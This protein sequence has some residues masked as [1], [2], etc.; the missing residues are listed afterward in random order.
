METSKVTVITEVGEWNGMNKFKVTLANGKQLTFLAKGNFK[1]NIGDSINYQITNEQYQTA[2]LLG[3]AEVKAPGSNQADVQTSII[4]Q[5]CLK[6][7]AEFY[8]TRQFADV[9]NVLETAELMYNWVI[10]G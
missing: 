7:S 3:K 5:T 10:N 6:A 4:R 2:K 8:S 1:A 9:E